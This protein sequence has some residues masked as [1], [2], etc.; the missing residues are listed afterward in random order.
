MET[1]EL[2]LKG[3]EAL[4]KSF[5]N[6]GSKEMRD[7]LKAKGKGKS[8][9]ARM[10]PKY[11]LSIEKKKEQFSVISRLPDY[12]IWVDKGRRPG[13]PPPLKVIVD[14][15]KR[16][17]INKK[18]AWGIA[19]NVGKKGLPATHFTSPMVNLND[20]ITKMKEEFKKTVINHVSLDIQ[21][22]YNDYR[23]K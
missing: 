23:A 5:V 1:K 10:N 11:F 16:K 6:R 3:I 8:R 19:K 18:Y 9:L 4:L 21:N 22:I 7:I 2:D 15:C 12:A 13:K 20:L 14:W 17:N